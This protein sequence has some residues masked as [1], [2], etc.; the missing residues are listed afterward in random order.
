MSYLYIA[1][2]SC[3]VMIGIGW[4]LIVIGHA[5]SVRECEERGHV[6][7]AVMHWR[8]YSYLMCVRCGRSH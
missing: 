4:F 3:L 7:Q 1:G 6:W 2:I 5:A 8:G